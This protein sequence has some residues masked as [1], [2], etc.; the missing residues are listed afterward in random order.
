MSDLE[1]GM[2]SPSIAKIDQ[3]EAVMKVHPLTVLTLSYCK[4]PSSREAEALMA[5]VASELDELLADGVGA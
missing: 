4:T 3:L 5:R 2:K 1:R